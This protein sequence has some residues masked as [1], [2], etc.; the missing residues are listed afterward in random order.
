MKKFFA[1]ILS[2]V[3]GIVL[4]AILHCSLMM[5]EMGGSE[6]LPTLEPSEKILIFLLADT[7]NLKKG[8]IIAYNPDFHEIGGGS[9]PTVRRIVADCGDEY[10]I[11]CDAELT[12][13]DTVTL[14]KE[15]VM[16]KVIK[17]DLKQ[18]I[19]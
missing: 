9:G 16:G 2:A 5:S 4:A 13:S 3:F 11:T 6:M 19:K 12:G 17:L 18:F 1:G 7:E 10:V 15:K 8:D 14:P